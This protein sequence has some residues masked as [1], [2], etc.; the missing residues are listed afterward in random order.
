MTS[1]RLIVQRRLSLAVPLLALGFAMSP[2]D[3]KSWLL[4]WADY[5]TIASFSGGYS[6][7]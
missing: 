7:E 2:D 1:Q 6:V 4:D 5:N 3:L